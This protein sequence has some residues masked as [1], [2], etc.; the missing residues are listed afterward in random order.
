MPGSTWRPTTRICFVST[1]DPD[2]G[3]LKW[4]FQF[5]PHDLFDYDATET[6]VLVDGTFRGQPRKL[7]VEA[8][9]NGFLYVLDRT[10]GSIL[11]ATRFAEK[12]N[13]ASGIDEEGRPI[14]TGIKPTEAGT[15]ICPGLVGATNWYA[16]SFNPDT[17]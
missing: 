8:H 6:P 7:V 13:W 14:R 4:Y 10:N 15:R 1:P 17:S 12:L 5:T 9:R 2:T 11:S 16:P 3:K